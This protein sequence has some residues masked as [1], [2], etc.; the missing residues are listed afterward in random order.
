MSITPSSA[1]V[2]SGPRPPQDSQ[3]ELV[4]QMY[5]LHH[6]DIFRYVR[7]R[8]SS[9]AEAEDIAA[10]VFCKAVARIGTYRQMRSSALP[11]LYTIAA[12]RVVDHYRAARPAAGIEEGMGISDPAP[13]ASEV[14]EAR[15]LVSQVWGLS[16]SLPPSQ[17]RALWLR[18]GA[19]L[20]LRE[21]AVRMSRS[22]EAVK[23]LVH[24]AIRTIR[25]RLVAASG[26]ALGPRLEPAR[27]AMPAP[28]AAEA[29]RGLRRAA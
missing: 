21:I 12:H 18:Y 20:E 11:W 27:I 5:V 24:R 28:V 13:D 19:D 8:V 4:K 25:A 26:T 1:T 6:G 2:G 7:S 14:V 9:Q 15:E 3:A 10:D 16:R 17:R 29:D 22:V 23:L